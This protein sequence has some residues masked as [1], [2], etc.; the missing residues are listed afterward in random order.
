MTII[1]LLSIHWMTETDITY[2]NSEPLN[3]PLETYKGQVRALT[4]RVQLLL[5]NV[6]YHHYWKQ[7]GG[8]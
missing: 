5:V 2:I 3:C 7:R 1:D 4:A 6:R 8:E